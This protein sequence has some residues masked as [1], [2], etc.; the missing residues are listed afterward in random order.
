MPPSAGRRASRGHHPHRQIE[1]SPLCQERRGAK[2]DPVHP[3]IGQARVAAHHHHIAGAQPEAVGG[4]AA[5]DVAHPKQRVIPQRDRDNGP[6]KLSLVAVLMHAHFCGLGVVVHQTA[7]RYAVHT[8][9]SGPNRQDL[10]RDRGPRRAIG[11][12]R[13]VPVAIHVREPAKTAKGGHPHRHALSAGQNRLK[14]RRF[15]SRST[16]DGDKLLLRINAQKPLVNPK[17]ANVEIRC[18]MRI[19]ATHRTALKGNA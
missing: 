17:S 5:R 12:M 13:R 8:G 15:G 10:V 16:Q 3:V 9:D 18:H 7:I 1:P 11:V 2:R 14:G 4:A 19:Q 6:L